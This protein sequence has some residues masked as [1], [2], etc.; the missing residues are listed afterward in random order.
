MVIAVFDVDD[1]IKRTGN[2]DLAFDFK[3]CATIRHI[4]D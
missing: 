2:A 1:K 4:A 3:I